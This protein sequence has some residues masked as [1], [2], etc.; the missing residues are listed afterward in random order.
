[1]LTLTE[2]QWLALQHDEARRFV[3]AVCDEFLMLR[4]EI[5]APQERALVLARMQQGYDYAAHAGFS[6]TPHVVRL[7]YLW[8]DAPNLHQDPLLERYFRRPG[9]TPEQRLDDLDAILQFH[10]KEKG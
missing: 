5:S 9:A 6:S 2:A 10:L 1:M 4:P 8:A 3:A 7:M